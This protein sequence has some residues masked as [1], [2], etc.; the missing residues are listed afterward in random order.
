MFIKAANKIAVVVELLVGNR[1]RLHD[2]KYC[3]L[4]SSVSVC[5]CPG[6]GGSKVLCYLN[7]DH[8]CA[9]VCNE[10][11]SICYC[12]DNIVLSLDASKVRCSSYSPHYFY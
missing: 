8:I 10:V 1:T 7:F 4:F 11:K 2:V 12:S 3:Y 5:V 6:K 9:S